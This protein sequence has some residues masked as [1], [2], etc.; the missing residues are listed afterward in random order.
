MI[1]NKAK[2]LSSK[3]HIEKSLFTGQKGETLFSDLC[4]KYDWKCIEANKSQ[5]IY[6][7]TDFYLFGMPVDVKGLKESHKKN[8]IVIEFKN[9]HGSA[10]WCSE[11]SKAKIIAFEFIEYFALIKKDELL[12][13]CR[14][15]VQN[16]YVNKFENCYKK[17]YTR[18]NRKDL[19][20]KLKLEDIKKFDV[21]IKMIK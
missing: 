19:M 2:K 11:E 7:H 3:K 6:E 17:L 12:K 16:I 18:K 14:N 21:F 5:N 20:T 10:G 13:Y 15:N 1:S 4:K 9:V 8:E